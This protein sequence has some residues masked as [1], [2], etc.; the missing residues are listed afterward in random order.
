MYDTAW[1]KS[2]KCPLITGNG[3]I[4]HDNSPTWHVKT[5]PVHGKS[6]CG[7]VKY[8]IEHDKRVCGHGI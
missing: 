4:G 5:P 3:S 1:T 7:H 8:K 6:L 2:S